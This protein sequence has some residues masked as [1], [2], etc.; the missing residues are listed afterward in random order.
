MKIRVYCD[1]GANI[2][3]CREQI[4]SFDELGTTQEDWENMSDLEKEDVIRPIAFE[5]LDWGWQELE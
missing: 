2:H 5:R 1:S 4:V 3:S